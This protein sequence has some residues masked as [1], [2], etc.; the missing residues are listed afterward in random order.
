MNTVC[1]ETKS[2]NTSLT[3][4]KKYMLTVE[5]ILERNHEEDYV[6]FL[7]DL[8][9]N[10]DFLDFDKEIDSHIKTFEITDEDIQ[11]EITAMIPAY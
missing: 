1:L 10:Q 7:Y 11:R 8:K 3:L 6:S 9:R 2:I 5:Y 4:Y